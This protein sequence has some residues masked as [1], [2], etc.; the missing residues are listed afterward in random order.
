M[1]PRRARDGWAGPPGAMGGRRTWTHHRSII[2]ITWAGGW[3]N[4]KYEGSSNHRKRADGAR[5]KDESRAALS[6]HSKTGFYAFGRAA[7]RRE[8]GSAVLLAIGEPR[9]PTPT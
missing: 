5:R 7:T 4:L 9:S 8:T 3:V 1:C 2:G 6:A